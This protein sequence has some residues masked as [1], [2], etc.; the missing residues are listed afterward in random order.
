MHMYV[1][2][3]HISQLFL[4]FRH[5]E[6]VYNGQCSGGGEALPHQCGKVRE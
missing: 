2:V 4:S 1:P 5:G 6:S 3:E